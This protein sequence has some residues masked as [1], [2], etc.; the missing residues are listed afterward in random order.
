MSKF[1]KYVIILSN[2]FNKMYGHHVRYDS[3]MNQ[4]LKE[5]LR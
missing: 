1:M 4:L 2:A 3:E 5:A